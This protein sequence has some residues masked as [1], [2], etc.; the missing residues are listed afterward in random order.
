MIDLLSTESA[1]CGLNIQA[2]LQDALSMHTAR[3]KL[4]GVK[5]GVCLSVSVKNGMVGLKAVL[6]TAGMQCI[7]KSR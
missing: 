2:R 6:D 5:A 3:S 4:L 7:L 1:A